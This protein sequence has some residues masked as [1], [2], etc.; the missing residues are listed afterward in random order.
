M[1]LTGSVSTGYQ[2][3]I[4]YINFKHRLREKEIRNLIDCKINSIR[5]RILIHV[6]DHRAVAVETLNDVIETK[7]LKSERSGPQKI[8][9]FENCILQTKNKEFRFVKL[10]LKCNVVNLF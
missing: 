2:T 8:S 5:L 4:Q 7:Q 6:I 3:M 9:T 10:S 1:S